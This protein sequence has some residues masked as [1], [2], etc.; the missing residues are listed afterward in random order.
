MTGTLVGNFDDIELIDFEKL[1]G[2]GRCRS[3]HSA[4]FRVH[5]E[6][7]LEGNRRQRLVFRFDPNAFFGLNRLVQAVRPAPPIHHPAGKFIDDDDLAVLDDIVG[8]ALEHDIGFE[9][10]VEMVDD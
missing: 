5:A 6:I 10:L 3:G 4:N 9:R 1:A 8:V 7:I 2:F